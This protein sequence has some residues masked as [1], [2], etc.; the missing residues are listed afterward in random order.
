MPDNRLK[1]TLRP[2]SKSLSENGRTRL[3]YLKQLSEGA[4]HPLDLR[5]IGP[6]AWIAAPRRANQADYAPMIRAIRAALERCAD[7]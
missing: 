5:Q 3:L 2:A 6:A 4:G 1:K 7:A